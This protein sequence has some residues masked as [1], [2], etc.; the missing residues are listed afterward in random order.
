M[1]RKRRAAWL[2]GL[3]VFVSTPGAA[4]GPSD[5]AVGFQAAERGNYT[6]AVRYYT[7]ALWSQE[8]SE[9]QAAAV[10][11]GR[12]FAHI[13]LARF[14]K[15][16]EDYTQVIALTP[17][18]AAAYYNRGVTHAAV[19]DLK[20][21]LADYTSAI[22]LGYND[23]YKAFFNRGTIYESKGDFERA[24]ADFKEAYR[25]APA[26]SRIRSKLQGLGENP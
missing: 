4:D 22:S 17:D 23:S 12:A 3:F 8:L 7:R 1:V 11:Y 10:H 24:V 16:V 5:A 19:G 21:A 9:Q 20:A 14:D 18:D 15:A 13:K 6:R 25:L 26:E 2:V